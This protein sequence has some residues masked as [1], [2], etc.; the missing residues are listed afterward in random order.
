MKSLFRRCVQLFLVTVIGFEL[1]FSGM[2]NELAIVSAQGVDSSGDWFYLYGDFAG[3]YF[4]MRQDT[5][6]RW[7]YSD[8]DTFAMV[9]IESSDAV[10]LHPGNYGN[11][12]KAWRAPA[13]GIVN[14][15]GSVH[16]KVDADASSE[17]GVNGIRFSLLKRAYNGD[18]Y[19]DAQVI[20]SQFADIKVTNST[21]IEFTIDDVDVKA[22][23]LIA[24]SVNNNGYNINDSNT[25]VFRTGFKADGIS[26][27]V[28][29][30]DIGYS[31]ASIDSFS[32]RQG[33]NGWFYAYGLVDK[34]MLMDWELVYGG[35]QWTSNYPFQF[36]GHTFMHPYGLYDNLKI[37]VSNFDGEIAVDGFIAK[38][39]SAGDG[40]VA[41]LYH[42]GKALWKQVCTTSTSVY[43]IPEQKLQVKKG[44]T[45]IFSYGTGGQHDANSDGG[46]FVTN[47]Y[48]LKVNSEST[49]ALTQH[50][51]LAAKESD[52]LGI[53]GEDSPDKS[54]WHYLYGDFSGRYFKMFKSSD[55]LWRYT[56][57]DTFAQVEIGSGGAVNLHPGNYGDTIK[58]WRAPADGTVNIAGSVKLNVDV[59]TAE[60]DSVDGIRF[61]LLKRSYT[62]DVYTEAHTVDSKYADV[63]VTDMQPV[64]FYVGD[65]AVKAGDLIALSVNNNGVNDSDGNAVRFQA[66]FTPVSEAQP[67]VLSDDLGCSVV[68]IRNYTNVQGE[69]GWFYAFGSV[70]SYQLMN[71]SYV[72]GAY[73]WTSHFPYQFIGQTVMHPYGQYDNL[74][75]WV[76]DFDGEIAISGNLFRSSSEGDG[77]V[78]GV[79]YNGQ[80]LWQQTC[81]YMGKRVY[82]IPEQTLSVKKGDTIIFSLGTG[83]KYNERGDSA[84]FITNIFKL[85]ETQSS[86]KADLISYLSLADNEAEMWKSLRSFDDVVSVSDVPSNGF[87][88]F[89]MI[90]FLGLGI[91]LLITVAVAVLIIM[92]KRRG[93]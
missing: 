75:I 60:S 12:I 9:E 2:G 88:T 86:D 37:W 92:L 1:L 87:W 46:N 74:K 7:S 48:K 78:A 81:D 39:S 31:V 47:I 52:I 89:R 90:V 77:A 3:R 44:D 76:S 56:D 36:I 58:A 69:Y 34:Y 93:K 49:G 18:T 25:V 53:D 24:L 51:N 67:P 65:I 28:L 72:Y 41:G 42:N 80:T 45:V 33:T 15:N 20:N 85:K 50:L 17:E 54:N 38:E 71:W 84:E 55:T 83:E 57:T 63:A 43:R 79:Y 10:N 35:Y 21:A 29:P 14:L 8:A 68:P 70:K 5:N 11:T 62:D 27:P 82:K 6:G 26:K 16:L 64:E 32:E 30:D 40:A 22:G 4:P 66:D 61:S 13:D 73:Q 91:F 59:A 19:S 23:D